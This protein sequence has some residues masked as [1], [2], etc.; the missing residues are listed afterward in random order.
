MATLQR[1]PRTWRQDEPPNSPITIPTPAKVRAE[2][3]RIRKSWSP[4]ER[5]RRA[6]LARRLLL[7]QWITAG[8]DSL[9]IAFQQFT[10]RFPPWR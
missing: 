9:R 6:E 7:A 3:A 8:D 2:A 4:G 10:P 5:L 1:S